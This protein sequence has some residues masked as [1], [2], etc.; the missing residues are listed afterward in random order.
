MAGYKVELISKRRKEA[1]IS[2]TDFSLLYSRKASIHGVCVKLFCQSHDILDMWAENFKPMSDDIRP[3]GR[4]FAISNGSGK[5]R[6]LY[7]PASN[8]VFLINCD[9]YGWVKSIALALASDCLWDSPSVENRRYPIHGSLV[10][11]RGRALAM[12]GM[13]KS[14]K[15][16]LTYGLLMQERFNFLTDDWFFVRFMGESTRVSSA[17]K[18]SYAGD[19][20]AKNWPELASRLREAKKDSHGRAVVDVARLFGAERIREQ[21]ELGAVVLL[22]RE[23]G[24]S[25]WRKLDERA[26]VRWMLKR[27]FCN[28]H[29]LTRT[30]ERKAEQ[31]AFFSELFSRVPVYLLNTIETPKASLA[32]LLELV[33]EGL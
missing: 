14:G 30:R 31:A 20:I 25:V 17:E 9:Y 32:H 16:T 29:Q 3:H 10:D 5:L 7:E 11:V 2:K 6:V 12:I 27:D 8:T 15:T 24:K 33:D 23:E 1:L 22:T 18:N 21:S 28:P 26:A 4:L 19:D 13:P